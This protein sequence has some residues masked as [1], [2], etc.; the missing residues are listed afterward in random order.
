[1]RIN[2]ESNVVDNDVALDSG[3]PGGQSNPA[4]QRFPSDVV[5][6]TDIGTREMGSAG[7]PPAP[8]ALQL[9]RSYAAGGDPRVRDQ[10]VLTFAPMVQYV[11]CRKLS[12]VL[13]HN[14]L[15]HVIG[16]G[17][18]ALIHSFDRYDPQR[19]VALEEFVWMCVLAGVVDELRA[20]H[21]AARSMPRSERESEQ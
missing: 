5:A 20:N 12:D 18:R 21:P 13:A 16:Q 14:E 19:G 15:E 8:E 6:M 9:W 10:L 4:H 11:V 2:R 3:Q 7:H 1:V 17:L